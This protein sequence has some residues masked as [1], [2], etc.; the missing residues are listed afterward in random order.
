MLTSFARSLLITIAFT[1]TSLSVVSAATLDLETATILDL[2]KAY[3]AGLTSE[4]VVAAYLK[5]IEAYDQ[6]GPK[7]NAILTLNPKALAQQQ[8][9]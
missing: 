9:S 3:D 8:G 5:R 1:A 2:Q 4:K 6:A 7:L